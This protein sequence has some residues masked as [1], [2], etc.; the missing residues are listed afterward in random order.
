MNPS[1]LGQFVTFTASVTATVG[2]TI[3]SG[4]VKFMEGS[5]LLAAVNL[6]DAGNAVF[7]TAGLAGG[8]H[9]LS[10]VFATTNVWT[11]STGSLTQ[12][13][14]GAGL[15]P[16]SNLTA[17]GGPDD[18]EITLNWSPSFSPGNSVT[19][20]IFSSASQTGPFSS[21]GTV[22]STRF[23]HG[24]PGSGIGQYYYVIAKDSAGRTSGKSA[25]VYARS[26]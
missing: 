13:V 6:D 8:T 11:G 23:V 12:T 21:V 2:T 9:V 3:P 18:S 17:T 5:T 10:A 7:K 22:S 1:N 25:I 20:Q 24:L 14:N 26:Y 4:T 15:A 19:Y 16:P